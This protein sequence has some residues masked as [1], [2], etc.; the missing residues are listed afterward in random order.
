MSVAVLED[1]TPCDTA[2]FRRA[3]GRLA[4]G[5]ALV[6]CGTG[7]ERRGLTATAVCS[8]CAEPPT[9]LACV[10]RSTQAHRVIEGTGRFCINLLGRDH[11]GLAETFAGRRGLAGLDRFADGRWHDSPRG[12]GP[13]LVDGPASLDCRVIRVMSVATHTVFFGLVE[14]ARV[15]EDR[16]TLAYCN[17][18]FFSIDVGHPQLAQ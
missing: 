15:A 3:M 16:A 1:G 14:D 11:T 6:T 10:N 5:V 9:I 7:S 18:S 17:G 13:L 4:S 8:V 2:A 12:S